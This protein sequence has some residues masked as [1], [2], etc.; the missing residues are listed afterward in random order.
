MS[1]LLF[2]GAVVGTLS[3]TTR[4]T[5]SVVTSAKNKAVLIGVAH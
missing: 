2:T 5:P 1:V 4:G 3:L